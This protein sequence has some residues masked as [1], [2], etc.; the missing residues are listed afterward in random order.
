MERAS[1]LDEAVSQSMLNCD[2]EA[3]LVDVDPSIHLFF[4]CPQLCGPRRGHIS[5]KRK[6]ARS[7]PPHCIKADGTKLEL[8]PP[9]SAHVKNLA[10]S[11]A[12]TTPPGDGYERH[13]YRW[14]PRMVT[15]MI[16]V[17]WP[18]GAGEVMTSGRWCGNT[19]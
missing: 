19:P 16:H 10:A 3:N 6:G 7:K 5:H 2:E 1:A 18:P 4:L 8:L 13:D 9:C 14:A 15:S 11:A 12:R 17:R